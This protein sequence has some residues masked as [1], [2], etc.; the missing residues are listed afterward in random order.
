MQV[1]GQ[2]EDQA[3]SHA[4][5]NIEDKLWGGGTNSARVPERQ[6]GS[7]EDPFFSGY[8]RL[9]HWIMTSFAVFCL[10]PNDKDAAVSSVMDP[11][12]SDCE[13]WKGMHFVADTSGTIVRTSHKFLNL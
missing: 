4:V 12:V 7:G 13:V 5:H 8:S 2:A 11:G 6:P 9:T 3:A 1:E 10:P